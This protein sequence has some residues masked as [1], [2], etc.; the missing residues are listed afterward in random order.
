MIR[1]DHEENQP[2]RRS[3]DLSASPVETTTIGARLHTIYDPFLAFECKRLPAPSKDREREYVTGGIRQKSGG[4]QRFK[5]GVHAP[6]LDLA[7]MIGYVQEGSMDHWHHQIN[8]WITDLSGETITDYCA[9]NESERLQPLEENAREGVAS[10]RS[11]HNRTGGV[12]SDELTIHH[13]W[14]AMR[15]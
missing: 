8:E 3:V 14:V 2:A 1:F 9:W 10:C 7:V 15:M 11:V 12:S 6:D 13:L 4:I 5:L